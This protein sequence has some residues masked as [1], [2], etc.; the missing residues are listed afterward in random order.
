MS[1]Q[2]GDKVKGVVS[3][4]THFGAFVKLETGEKG[5]IHISEIANSYVKNVSDHLKIGDEVTVKVIAIK[6]RGKIDLSIRR[7]NEEGTPVPR[8][9]QGRGPQAQRPQSRGPQSR[10][11]QGR[12]PFS[13]GSQSQSFSGDNFEDKLSFFM[14]KSQEKLSDAK[15]RKEK[16]S[17]GRRK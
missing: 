13:R 12:K 6:D 16:R 9:P 7:L 1:V 3:D 4:V 11:P 8:G 15:K 2:E 17:R 10:G 14:K 5:L